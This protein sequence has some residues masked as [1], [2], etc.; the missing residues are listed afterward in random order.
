[1]S[2][3]FPQFQQQR[4]HCVNA[5]L[6]SCPK[7]DDNIPYEI[8]YGRAGYLYSCIFVYKRLQTILNTSTNEMK[9]Q[10]HENEIV[11]FLVIF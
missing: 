10:I 7:S 8:L 3:Q 6:S 2:N 5:L 4:Q 11:Q 9:Q 1:M